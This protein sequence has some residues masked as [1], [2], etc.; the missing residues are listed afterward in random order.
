[1]KTNRQCTNWSALPIFLIGLVWSGQLNAAN[2]ASVQSGNWENTATWDCGCVPGAGDAITISGGTTV[3]VNATHFTGDLTVNGTLDMNDQFLEFEGTT[4]ANHG[5][6]F[7]STGS[8]GEIDFVGMGGASATTQN[9]AGTGSYAAGVSFPID[10]DILNTTTVIPASGT[11]IS[12]VRNLFVQNLS[13]LSLPN[14]FVFSNG[15]INSSGMVSGAGALQTDGPVTLS[16]SGTTTALVETVNGTTTCNGNFG[17][18]TIDNGA[19]LFQNGIVTPNGNFTVASGGTLDMNDQFLE[20]EGTTFANHGSIFSS[21]GS[22]G[23]IDFVGMGGASATTQ[24]IAGTGS[25]AAGMSFPID[26]DI[27]NTTT[28][29]P[30]SGTVISGVRT[31]FVQNLST[32]SLPHAFVFSNGSINSSGMVSGVGALQTD[33]P[34]TLSFSGTT[35]AL[36]E[37]VTGTTTC[38]GN[39]GP[40]TIDNGAALFQ[41]GTVTPSGNFTVVSGG[42]LDM[43]DQFLEFEGTTFANHGSIFSSTGSYGEIDFVGMGGAS[44]TTQNIV[45]TGSYAAGVSF[46]I[47]IDILNTTTVIPASG[48]VISGV[49]NLFVQNLSTLSLPNAFVFSNGSIN[50]SGM[51][52]GAG[53]LQTDGPVTLSFSGTTTALV[54]TVNGTTTCNGNF[55]PVTIDNGATLFQ[56]GTL[57]PNGDFTVASGGTLD[58][59]DQFL[60]FQGTTFANNGALIS[61]VPYGVFEFNGVNGVGAT[62]QNV[63]GTGSYNTNGRVDFRVLNNVTVIATSVTVL[64]GVANYTIDGGSTLNNNGTIAPG[65]PP[66][67]ANV[68]GDLELGST[69]DLFFE[70]GGTGQGTTYDLLNKTDGAAQTLAGNL[71]VRLINGF[72][73]M[74]SDMFAIVTTQAILQGA[75]SNVPNGTRLDTED[76]G[77]SFKVTYN[78]INDPIASRNVVLSDFQPT[79]QCPPT[80]I[81][82]SRL[83]AIPSSVRYKPECD[84][85]RH[86]HS[87]SS[88][89]LP[90][91][92]V[93]LAEWERDSGD[94]LHD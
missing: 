14:A 33:G 81:E 61:S 67:Q 9:I 15:S 27:L 28:V 32:L 4:F 86:N 21:T 30:L 50:S 2:V 80:D 82:I 42:T 72:I 44:A 8:Y 31:L 64:D 83:S 93:L 71:R 40:V 73:P 43:N 94:R 48:T 90:A 65:F 85:Y 66:G 59:N 57:T 7:S 69:S 1:M 88:A 11:V 10:I 37:T 18:V 89:C 29:I 17:P 53:A 84:L 23:E 41:N 16:F 25:Y 62:A 55:G 58:M 35:T 79:A 22:A 60:V 3:K 78:V 12:G 77:G 38:N 39:F 6:I 68:S 47:D 20:F 49:R 91:D 51:V 24:N 46:P 52:S 5:S 92:R 75:F 26:I 45:G 54:E 70:I 56:N 34:V 87:Q 19:T 63:A 36:V 13:T 76:G 74:N